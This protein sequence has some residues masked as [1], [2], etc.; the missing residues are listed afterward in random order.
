MLYILLTVVFCLFLFSMV[1]M[2]LS[3][4]EV[5]TMSE[6]DNLLEVVD[7]GGKVVGYLIGSMHCNLTAE[8][9][10]PMVKAIEAMAVL[11][12]KLFLE[13]IFTH[14]TALPEGVERK[15]LE[16]SEKQ[17]KEA[18][19][20][21]T[22]AF[23]QALI[24]SIF[25]VGS[26]LYALPYGRLLYWA[27]KLC[28]VINMW[29]VFVWL[30][31]N[32]I[33]QQMINPGFVEKRN[34]DNINKLAQLR[35]A[36]MNGKTPIMEH[37]DAELFRVKTRDEKIFQKLQAEMDGFSEKSRFLLAIGSMHL[38]LDQG[39]ISH[40]KQAGYTIQPYQRETSEV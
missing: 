34:K 33:Y 5:L 21:E 20:V 14:W 35:K 30:I 26:Q 9:L 6:K 39:I 22:H 16:I 11:S 7:Q 24:S 17:N 13:C 12:D 36:F 1:G 18:I 19:S 32:I 4:R 2:F 37:R 3:R 38:V 29:T 10:E 15:V 8:E 40:F 23:Q 27:P 25:G 28:Q 31:P